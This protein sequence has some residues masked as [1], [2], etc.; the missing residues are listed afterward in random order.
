MVAPTS[1]DANVYSTGSIPDSVW[2][3]RTITRAAKI[4]QSYIRLPAGACP[5]SD[6]DGEWLCF[7]RTA[8]CSTAMPTMVMSDNKIVSWIATF[9]DAKLGDGTGWWNCRRASM[10]PTFAGLIRYG[11]IANGLI[12]H[13]LVTSIGPVM[14]K[15]EA[16][17]PTYAF[18]KNCGYS[19]TLPMGSLLAIPAFYAYL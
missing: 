2:Q 9:I 7:N 13:A 16:V 17:W 15:A 8:G 1:R 5:S 12:P 19:G 18:G 6:T 3:S 4:L 10:L 11:E 14:L